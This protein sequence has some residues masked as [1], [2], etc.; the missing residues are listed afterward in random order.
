MEIFGRDSV[1]MW[2]ENLKEFVY[3]RIREAIGG[4]FSD[5]L[6]YKAGDGT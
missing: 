3:G 5:L 2:L 1:L 4:T 6:G